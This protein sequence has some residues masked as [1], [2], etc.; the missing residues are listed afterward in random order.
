MRRRI[1]L[2]IVLVVV[3]VAAAVAW[4]YFRGRS[5]ATTGP[6]SASGT[7]EAE[8]VSITAELGGRV[9]RLLADE[10]DEVAQE[11][12]VVEL[13]TALLAAQTKQ[14]EAALA[15]AQAQL[16]QVRAGA[17][18]EDVRAA[19]ANRDQ[20]VAGREGAR[21]AWENAVA[22]RDNPQEL[23][24]K[25]EA[26]QTQLEVAKHQQV[27]AQSALFAAQV[28]RDHYFHGSNGSDQE[29]AR[30]AAAEQQVAAADA[31]LQVAMTAVDQAQRNLDNLIVQR[32]N[33]IT[34]DAQVDAAQAQYEISK[35]AADAA[36]ARLDAL[37]AGATKEQIA[38]AEA[39]VSQAQAA[40]EALQV[41]LGK[42]TLRSPIAGLVTSRSIH[43]GEVAAPGATLLTIANLDSVKLTVY[44]P[45][46]R[47]GLVKVGQKV[48]VS[49][50][51]FPGE[52]FVGEVTFIASHAEFT[53][54]NVQTKEG[55]VSTVFAVKVQIP[56]LEHKLKPGMPAD[57]TIKM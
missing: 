2:A 57:A 56:N 3:V 34:L 51:S 13:G 31:G 45:E 19:Q 35:A 48:E 14:A 33:P 9:Q 6:L 24:L 39:Q 1:V 37:V 44:I 52:T 4:W 43:V 26:A 40:L 11:A 28:Q 46:D 50:D 23:N 10:G 8:E 49:V 15:V 47:I 25:I 54:K 55:R 38:V 36:Q 7:I 21:K 12:V 53:P 30:Y 22:L 16:A 27:Q 32:D 41:Q 5:T 29:K 17:R 20:A 18:E 42:L